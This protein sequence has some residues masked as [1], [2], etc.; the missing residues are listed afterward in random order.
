MRGFHLISNFLVRYRDAEVDLKFER[1]QYRGGIWELQ[2]VSYDVRTMLQAKEGNLCKQTGK[3]FMTTRS[4]VTPTSESVVLLLCSTKK[5][6]KNFFFFR[7]LRTAYYLRK[8]RRD[9][10]LS[11]IDFWS[12]M[13]F[14]F[15]AFYSRFLLL[16]CFSMSYWTIRVG[17]GDFC[18]WHIYIFVPQNRSLY[19]ST[20]SKG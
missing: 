3:N 13:S 1:Y 20:I 14:V 7:A 9:W 12:L 4:N 18:R 8:V 6:H 2:V 5:C 11:Q 15:V 17:K 19:V 10:I 16:T